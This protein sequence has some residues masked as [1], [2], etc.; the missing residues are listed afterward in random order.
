MEGRVEIGFEFKTTC[1]DIMIDLSIVL[2]SYTIM[3]W[4]I[5]LVNK[6]QCTPNKK[7]ATFIGAFSNQSPSKENLS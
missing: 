3:K 5:L 6:W 2:K 1:S 7:N 4:W